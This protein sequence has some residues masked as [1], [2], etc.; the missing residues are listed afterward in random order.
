MEKPVLIVYLEEINDHK[1]ILRIKDSILKS[2][3]NE[4]HVLIVLNSKETKIECLNVRDA[5]ETTILELQNKILKA[6]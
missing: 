6:L 2:V 3:D 1:E 4:Y 5:D